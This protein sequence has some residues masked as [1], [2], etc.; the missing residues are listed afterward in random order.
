MPRPVR[1]PVKTPHPP[2]R[3]SDATL[4]PTR[5]IDHALARTGMHWRSPLLHVVVSGTPVADACADARVSRTMY[6]HWRQRFARVLRL[7]RATV[8]RATLSTSTP[9]NPDASSAGRDTG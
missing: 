4:S 7:P 6:S 8:H 1:C 2:G 3:R 5:Q 9:R